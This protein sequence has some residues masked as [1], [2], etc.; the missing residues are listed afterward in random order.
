MLFLNIK[1]CIEYFYHIIAK[2]KNELLTFLGRGEIFCDR[3]TYVDCCDIEL[4]ECPFENIT[5]DEGTKEYKILLD[6]ILETKSDYVIEGYSLNPQLFFDSIVLSMIMH[7]SYDE[8]YYED[9]INE[10]RLKTAVSKIMSQIGLPI[11]VPDDFIYDYH[12]HLEKIKNNIVSLQKNK[13]QELLIETKDLIKQVGLHLDKF[14]IKNKKM[15]VS[16]DTNWEKELTN[17]IN[18]NLKFVDDFCI[19]SDKEDKISRYKKKIVYESN[20]IAEEQFYQKAGRN[21]II[22]KLSN[23]LA[24]NSNIFVKEYIYSYVKERMHYLNLQNP[25]LSK[26]I[27]Y[28]KNQSIN[29]SPIWHKIFNVFNFSLP[30][31]VIHNILYK[32]GILSDNEFSDLL[33]KH[34]DQYYMECKIDTTVTPTKANTETNTPH[35]IPD[36]VMN[37]AKN[38]LLGIDE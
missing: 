13:N 2:K 32:Q 36:H 25:I 12:N 27:T 4:E 26:E 8:I 14:L 11:L 28:L 35:N 5:K 34:L 16:L 15:I 6:H 31:T 9:D 24:S 7:R 21:I 10:K 19:S 18:N 33:K 1:L 3:Y 20:N 30:E 38:I 23:L 22:D 29:N 37:K 17:L